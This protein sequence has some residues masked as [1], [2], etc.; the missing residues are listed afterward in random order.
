MA[1]ISTAFNI[2]TRYL[3]SAHIERDFNDPSALDGYIVT[4]D[5]QRC[6]DRISDGLDYRSG[7][8]AWRITGDYGSGKSSLALLL[9]HIL[10]GRESDL[11]SQIRRSIDLGRVRKNRPN[12][13]PVL[14]TGS[15]ESLGAVLLRSLKR[16]VDTGIDKRVKLRHLEPLEH[17]IRGKG[18]NPSDSEVIDLVEKINLELIE[19]EQASGLL[20]II[21]E[22]GKFLEFSALH[23][24]R[25]DVYVLQQ[26]AE[27][28]SRSGKR[29]IF[30]VGLL[31]QGFS[32]YAD[33]L[34]QPL[35]R[36]WDKVA[37]RFEELIF[38]Q[39]LD[40]IT[41][42][43]RHA[44]DLK[45]EA[46]PRGWESRAKLSMRNT[47]EL[48]WYGSAPPIT[49]LTEAAQAI[50]PLHPTVI[51]VL[52]RLFGRFGQNERSLFSFLLSN[53][54]HGLQNFAQNELTVDNAFR[55][56]H[57]YDYAATNFGH[58]LGAQSYRNHWNHIDSL[59][60]S[61]PSSKDL[62]L[63]VLKTVGLLNLI[64]SPEML[65]T[66][67]AIVTA[68]T[69]TSYEAPDEIK[70]TIEHL[71][72]EKNVLY[73][74]GKN[75]GYCLWS[76]T[77][78]NLQNAYEDAVKVIGAQRRVTDL[79]KGRLDPRPIVARRHYIQT[80]NL[81]Y[82]EVV[83]CT[84]SE[85]ERTVAQSASSA[86]GRIIIPLCETAE[87]V[88]QVSKLAD[89][90]TNQKNLLIGVTEPLG[91]LGGLIQEVERWALVEKNTPELKDDRYAFEEVSRQLANATQALE[92]RVQHY[93]GLR[94]AA[95]S[96]AHMPIRWYLEG[97]E[98]PMVTVAS[99]LSLL[100]DVCDAV[101]S[102]APTVSN[103][104]INRRSLSSAAAAARMR[105]IERMLEFSSQEY[106]GMDPDK[107]PPEMSMYLS[108][109]MD[110][111][112][113]RKVGS[114][115]VLGEPKVGDD[116]G[117]LLPALKRIKGILEEKPDG[118]FTVDA[119]FNELRKAPYGVREGL[120]P[121]LLLV[122]MLQHQQEIA[123]YENGT[124]K[125]QVT[126]SDILRLTKDTKVFELQYCKIQGVRLNVFERL[127]EVLNVHSLPVPKAEVLDIVRPLCV[128]A[129]EL[130]P[131]TKITKRLSDHALNV[132]NAIM[133]AR[134]PGNLLFHALPQACGFEPFMHDQQPNSHAKRTK[135]F[136]NELQR[137][138]E[139]L[140]F[141][142]PSLYDRM[143]QKISKAFELSEQSSAQF[144]VTRDL[145]AERSENL[146]VHITDLDLRA[147][148]LRFVDNNMPQTDWLESLGSY[149]AAVPP[150][151]WK[152]E[153]ET[154]FEEKLKTL[155]HKLRRV[156]SVNFK[157]ANRT[158]TNAS[159]RI[160]ITQRD[161]IEKEEVIYLTNQEEQSAKDLEDK[162]K[163]LLGS[164]KRVALSAL[165]RLA[166]QFLGDRND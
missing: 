103:E 124:F 80:G 55:L 108:V 58:K 77:S 64:N 129:A 22:L 72:R 161:G 111:K 92:K 121:M 142:L 162:V 88:A 166:W 10:S 78:V 133:D 150:S 16:A 119:I 68:L 98:R 67:E 97:S 50:Y 122:V 25:Q 156:E 54:Q 60:R 148:C 137:C 43:V 136:V 73:L 86:D 66:E 116:P 9:S 149:V 131:Y 120:L 118:R 82:F 1:R 123:V 143:C 101:Y 52:V 44:L 6:V 147:F 48:G 158:N 65:P 134:D 23:P 96:G 109:L 12:L 51:P 102:D 36:E 3:R 81:R 153:E 63:K 141:A 163:K 164:N 32:A 70:A 56:H 140:K 160:A 18:A 11:P 37:G 30:T 165:S 33:N 76:H 38:D 40:Q 125:S 130:P 61:F 19:K 127:S 39:P 59:V 47:I 20:I 15:R 27:L 157:P 155:A 90:I 31:H 93:V 110:T 71:Y 29:P 4:R 2:R 35:Q 113:H 115:W 95:Q 105:L 49:S 87:E 146:V 138:L 84:T 100:S 75:G 135:D 91:V 151:R 89:T 46:V 85:L 28:S 62:E 128:F 34:S 94:E 8:R 14:I 42:L 69:D 41:H 152:D 139:E 83:Y 126:S 112:L 13:L 154:A 24:E 45:S 114:K 26:L 145:L 74:R 117:H 7:Q 79:I 99:F 17:L 144:Q 104:L 5:V 159:V 57:L 107:K 132:R 21:D 53:E 106:L